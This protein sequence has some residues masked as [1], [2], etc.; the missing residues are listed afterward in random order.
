M[1]ASHIM[2]NE[3]TDQH[4]Q[5]KMSELT[6]EKDDIERQLSSTRKDKKKLVKKYVCKNRKLKRQPVFEDNKLEGKLEEMKLSQMIYVKQLK[7][8]KVEKAILLQ[9]MRLVQEEKGKPSSSTLAEFEGDV[10][11]LAYTE[12][13]PNNKT[14]HITLLYTNKFRVKLVIVSLNI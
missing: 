8:A 10:K 7:Q 3:T 1:E 13:F 6:K 14:G 12:Q 2:D 11:Q 4:Q 9:Q 5:L